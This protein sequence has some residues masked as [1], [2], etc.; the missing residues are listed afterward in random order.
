MISIFALDWLSVYSPI[1]LAII[2]ESFEPFFFFLSKRE[3]N[4]LNKPH[5]VKNL[6]SNWGFVRQTSLIV[7]KMSSTAE[8]LGSSTLSFLLLPEAAVSLFNSLINSNRSNPRAAFTVISAH[9][10]KVVDQSQQPIPAQE[11][12]L[13][14]G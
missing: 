7:F 2:T 3:N 6:A 13:L 9:I 10:D 8:M 4:I 12:T 14:N 11:S 5:I 1:I